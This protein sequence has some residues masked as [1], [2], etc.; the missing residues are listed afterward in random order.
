MMRVYLLSLAVVSSFQVMAAPL[1]VEDHPKRKS[2][3]WEIRTTSPGVRDEARRIEMC[4]DQKADDL[5][6]QASAKAK[7]LCSKTDIQRQGGRVT[8][9]S[10][11]KFGQ[12]TATT[13]TVITGDFDSAYHVDTSSTYDP[14]MHNSRE[15]KAVLDAKWLGPCRADQRPGD[16]ILGNGTRINMHDTAKGQV[17]L[18]PPRPSPDK[19]K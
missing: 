11:C 19:S 6:G 1:T 7:E 3:L 18:P 5:I 16:V 10:V 15:M 14:P 8:I 4:V 12:T 2:G 13:R 17:V 9:N